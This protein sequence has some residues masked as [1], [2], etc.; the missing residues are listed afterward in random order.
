[1]AKITLYSENNIQHINEK[2]RKFHLERLAF[3]GFRIRRRRNLLSRTLVRDVLEDAFFIFP[4]NSFSKTLSAVVLRTDDLRD[5]VGLDFP[6]FVMALVRLFE[7][8]P[9]C[10]ESANDII[11]IPER[12]EF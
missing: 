3:K 11:D 6:D 9:R 12:I 4:L 1:M 8:A 7:L 10:R 2:Y 5:K